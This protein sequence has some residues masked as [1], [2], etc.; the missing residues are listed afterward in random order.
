MTLI[1]FK[2]NARVRSL[3]ILGF[4]IA[5]AIACRCD[6]DVLTNCPV[7]A[8]DGE[9]AANCVAY[10]FDVCPEPDISDPN[11][12]AAYQLCKIQAQS[13]FYGQGDP[14]YVDYPTYDPSSV[15]TPEPTLPALQTPTGGGSNVVAPQN[16]CVGFRLASPREGLPNG[17]VNI[18]WDMLPNRND[19]RYRINI[20]DEARNVLLTWGDYNGNGAQLDVAQGSIGGGFE[21]IVQVQVILN[22]QVLCADEARQFREASAPNQPRRGIIIIPTPVPTAVIN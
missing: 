13:A 6:P 14:P 22:G 7:W 15:T 9:E 1:Q 10:V 17:Y 18:Y 12:I 3:L 19:V 2:P 8:E 16:P 11:A 20:M 21:L 4:L 5:L